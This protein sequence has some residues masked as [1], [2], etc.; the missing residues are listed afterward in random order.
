MEIEGFRR[1]SELELNRWIGQVRTLEDTNGMHQKEFAGKYE[2]QE[3][4]YRTRMEEKDRQCQELHDS[5]LANAADAEKINVL[6]HE[7]HAA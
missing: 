6:Y 7:L 4:E 5:V 1:E 3:M 2:A